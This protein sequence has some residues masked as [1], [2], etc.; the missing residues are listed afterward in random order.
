MHISAKGKKKDSLECFYLDYQVVVLALCSSEG[1]LQ[2]HDLCG[3]LLRDH[4]N[5]QEV[6]ICLKHLDQS[7]GDHFRWVR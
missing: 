1:F 2:S 5:L 3:P 7:A 4:H 6:A